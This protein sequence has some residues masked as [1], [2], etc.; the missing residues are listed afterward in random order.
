MVGGSGSTLWAS[1]VPGVRNVVAKM[2]HAASPGSVTLSLFVWVS[3]R[4][5]MQMGLGGRGRAVSVS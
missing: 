4:Y 1:G 3:L 2:R 5:E